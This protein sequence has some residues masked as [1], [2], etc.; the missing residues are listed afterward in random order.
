MQND[1]KV[2]VERYKFKNVK[3][4]Q[5]SFEGRFIPQFEYDS[6]VDTVEVKRGDY[7]VPTA[8]KTLPVIAYLLEPLSPDSFVKW[9]F[10]NGI[11]E[12]KEYFEE[13][14]MEPIAEKM[15]EENPKLKQEFMK[16]VDSD[17]KF[18]ENPRKRLSFF[19][20]RSPYFDKQLNVYPIMRVIKILN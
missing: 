8:Q 7:L 1:S 5:R 6:F 4:P 10:M 2:I 18:K 16:K 13:Y 17:D 3:F 19:Y 11:F 20:E 12:Q 9:G 15:A 14:S